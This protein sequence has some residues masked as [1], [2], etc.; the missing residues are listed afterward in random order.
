MAGRLHRSNLHVKHYST[1][2]VQYFLSQRNAQHMSESSSWSVSSSSEQE[3]RGSTRKC[4]FLFIGGEMDRFHSD[5]MGHPRMWQMHFRI[6]ATGF[7]L[8]LYFIL[9]PSSV[10]SIEL[11]LHI[12]PDPMSPLCPLAAIF[13]FHVSELFQLFSAC[14]HFSIKVCKVQFPLFNFI[15]NKTKQNYLLTI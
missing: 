14:C 3:L 7:L 2:E 5:E 15:E 11:C 4:I 13:L 6:E 8:G 12:L 9:F 10:S 1:K